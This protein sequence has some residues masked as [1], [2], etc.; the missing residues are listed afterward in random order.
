M[1]QLVHVLK[2]GRSS[3]SLDMLVWTQLFLGQLH[4]S[5]LLL[6]NF[7]S[8]ASFAYKVLHDNDLDF[9]SQVTAI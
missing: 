3:T 7:K 4:R 2:G 5:I 8:M 9:L 1:L 6:E